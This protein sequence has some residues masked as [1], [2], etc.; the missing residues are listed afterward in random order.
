MARKLPAHDKVATQRMQRLKKHEEN[1]Q[2]GQTDA[3]SSVL[4]K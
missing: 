1:M 4:W 3:N 2:I